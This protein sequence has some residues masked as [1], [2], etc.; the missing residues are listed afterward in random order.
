MRAFWRAR[1]SSD[2]TDI[3]AS[4]I[5]PTAE[6]SGNRRVTDRA[7]LLCRRITP[8]GRPPRRGKNHH[9][10]VRRR[11][12]ITAHEQPFGPSLLD[13]LY[14]FTALLLPATRDDNLGPL[15]GEGDGRRSP[16]A[17][18]STSN[19][20]DSSVECAHKG[21]AYL[22]PRGLGSRRWQ[23]SREAIG[24]AAKSRSRFVPGEE[25]SGPPY[26]SQAPK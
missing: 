12:H 8:H 6:I 10:H 15:P 25:I 13:Q 4:R 26:G 9:L 7:H 11:R 24:Q 3:E 21:L 17:G 16:D 18:R 5:K 22:S 14:G 1:C 19:E 20:G 2:R 23:K